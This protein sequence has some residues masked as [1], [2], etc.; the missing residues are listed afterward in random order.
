MATIDYRSPRKPLDSVSWPRRYA[1]ATATIGA[2]YLGA[3]FALFMFE[4]A[5][6]GR[7]GSVPLWVLFFTEDVFA[8]PMFQL[9]RP[10]SGLQDLGL[11]I[12]NALIWGL[13]GAAIWH[14]AHRYRFRRRRRPS[15]E[16]LM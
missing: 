13:L 2:L 3:A 14:A 9:F 7:S 11:A 10:T 15:R 16:R 4:R 8:F 12:A 6:F 5:N 1:L